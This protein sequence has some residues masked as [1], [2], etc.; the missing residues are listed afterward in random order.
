MSTNYFYYRTERY[1][2][3]VAYT[4]TDDNKIIFGASF[5][6]PGDNFVKKLGRQI[7]EGRM[8]SNENWFFKSENERRCDTHSVILS[9]LD[10]RGD[11]SYTPKSFNP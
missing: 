7:A 4:S 3:T 2:A 5:C 9:Y 6:R 8:N 11:V 1:N 10:G